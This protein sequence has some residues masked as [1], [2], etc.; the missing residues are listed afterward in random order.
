[1]N[2]KLVLHS[3]EGTSLVPQGYA[4]KAMASLMQLHTELMEEKERRVDLYRRVM[5]KEQ[6]IAE[7]RMYV[8][9][10]E[11]KLARPQPDPEPVAVPVPSASLGAR[12]VE[13]RPAA[14]A[15]APAAPP[16]APVVPPRRP[17]MESWKAW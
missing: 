10:L 5:E 16:R 15:P 6:V 12:A 4:E 8:K 14:T 11:E 9:L 13:P 3:A 2:E 1:M 7:L 17:V